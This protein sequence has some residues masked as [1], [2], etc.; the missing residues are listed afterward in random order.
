MEVMYQSNYWSFNVSPPP[1]IPRA[2]DRALCPGRGGFESCLGRVGNL[3]QTYLL[4][5]RN[6]PVI[7]FF[8]FCKVWRI[9]KRIWPL[10]VNNSFKRDFKR[11]LKM[12]SRHISLWKVWTVFDWRRNLSLRRGISVLIGGT[13]EWLFCPEGREFEQANLQKFK[14]PGGRGGGRRG[15]LKFRFDWYIRCLHFWHHVTLSAE[16]TPV[17]EDTE[18]RN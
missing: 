13:F 15:M 7:F 6:I 5:W 3:N 14:C 1:G 9:H 2:F 8:G 10:L 18:V 17:I 12:S 4:F 16:T 11:S